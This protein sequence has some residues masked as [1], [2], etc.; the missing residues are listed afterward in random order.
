MVEKSLAKGLFLLGN[1]QWREVEKDNNVENIY[2][3]HALIT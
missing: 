1:L 2:D 3:A